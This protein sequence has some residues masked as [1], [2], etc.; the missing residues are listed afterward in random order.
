MNSKERVLKAFKNQTEIPTGCRSSLIFAGNTLKHFGKKLSI[1][2][3]YALS[4]YED[5]TYRISANEI[6]TKMGSDVVVVGGTVPQVT[7]RKQVSG[8]ITKK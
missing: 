1:E 4:Y 5:L 3:D 6:R 8:D 2:P 7:L